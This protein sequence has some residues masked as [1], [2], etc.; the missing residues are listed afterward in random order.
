MAIPDVLNSA[1]CL[2][3]DCP[4]PDIYTFFLAVFVMILCVVILV[5][6]ADSKYGEVHSKKN[7]W[8]A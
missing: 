6:Q 1:R 4:V 2:H 7:R 8:K 5:G 3:G